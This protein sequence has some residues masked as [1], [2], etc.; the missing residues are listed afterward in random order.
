MV[1]GN[2]P[3]VA[4]ALQEDTS[5]PQVCL[6]RHVCLVEIGNDLARLWLHAVCFAFDLVKL[7]HSEERLHG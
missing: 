6:V 3:Q 2:Y 7:C 5:E 4:D 1:I